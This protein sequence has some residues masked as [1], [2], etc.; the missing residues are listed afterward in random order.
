MAWT[1]DVKSYVHSGCWYLVPLLA[2]KHDPFLSNAHMDVCNKAEFAALVAERY[3]DH[4]RV[5]QR[6]EEDR[7]EWIEANSGWRPP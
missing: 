3:P 7:A 2:I 5:I 4:L 6:Y 1:I